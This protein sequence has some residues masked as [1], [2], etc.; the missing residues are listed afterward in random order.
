[1]HLITSSLF[2]SVLRWRQCTKTVT[3][4]FCRVIDEEHKR[5]VMS[6]V[7]TVTKDED[8]AEI[9]DHIL[10]LKSPIGVDVEGTHLPHLGLVQVKTVEG[11]IYLFR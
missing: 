7:T 8:S 5:S 1:M 9:V 2:R 3:R 11:N 4:P 6:K 10:K